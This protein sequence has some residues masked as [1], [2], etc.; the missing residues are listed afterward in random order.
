MTDVVLI[1]PRNPHAP[2][3]SVLRRIHPGS[4]LAEVETEPEGRPHN[5]RRFIEQEE[6]PSACQEIVIIRRCGW[7]NEEI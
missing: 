4:S 6:V 3:V 5:P 1:D 7:E 2:D